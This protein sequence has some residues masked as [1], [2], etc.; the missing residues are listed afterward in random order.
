MLR[1]RVCGWECDREGGGK[2][3]K[4]KERGTDF[5]GSGFGYDDTLGVESGCARGLGHSS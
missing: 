5:Q 2:G 3:R 4:G 1:E